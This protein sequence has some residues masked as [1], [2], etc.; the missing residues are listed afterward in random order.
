MNH[1][2]ATPRPWRYTEARTM[3]HLHG[4]DGYFGFSLP[5][6]TDRDYANGMLIVRVV[7]AWDDPVALR[8]RLD[9][10]E[11]KREAKHE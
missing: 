10:L 11:V 9:E 1:D 8:N 2:N 5:K 3:A 7:N 4:P 6:K